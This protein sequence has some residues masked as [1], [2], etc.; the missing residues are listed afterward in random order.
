MI[1]VN[2]TTVI[3]IMHVILKDV[4]LLLCGI[5]RVNV[6]R[7]H[8]EKRIKVRRYSLLEVKKKVNVVVLILLLWDSIKRLVGLHVLE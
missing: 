2:V 1:G 3:G 8:I 6:K 4:E 5:I 7:I